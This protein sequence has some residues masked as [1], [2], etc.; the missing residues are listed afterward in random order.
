[1]E[2][3]E[4]FEQEGAEDKVCQLAQA[5]YGLKQAGRTWYKQ[6]VGHLRSLGF[7]PNVA[8]ECIWAKETVDG[9]II[10]IVYVDHMMII[11]RTLAAV[12]VIV[13]RWRS[14]SN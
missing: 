13:V 1:M 9:P 8:D 6:L 14:S 5:L 11:G 2:Q 12:Q 7:A 4:G 3:P 10:M